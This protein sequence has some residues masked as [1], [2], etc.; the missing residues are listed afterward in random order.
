[1]LVALYSA[2]CGL[3]SGLRKASPLQTLWGACC[4]SHRRAE[5]TNVE[6][7]DSG[8][9]RVSWKRWKQDHHMGKLVDPQSPSQGVFA[10]LGLN[11]HKS[12]REWKNHGNIAG[13]YGTSAL[14]QLSVVTNLIKLLYRVRRSICIDLM[15]LV[16]SA[17]GKES[18]WWPPVDPG[19]SNPTFWWLDESWDISLRLW[20]MKN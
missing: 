3:H 19:Q 15:S 7:A 11:S 10:Q 17:L 16:L 13:R 18:C 14:P 2:T 1:M 9:C 12:L 8:R 4:Y 5:M 6:T 20:G